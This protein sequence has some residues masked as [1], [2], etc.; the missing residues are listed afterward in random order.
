M[1]PGRLRTFSIDEAAAIRR[2][3]V[4]AR[5]PVSRLAKEYHV[6]QGTMTRLLTCQG[7]YSGDPDPVTI[8]GSMLTAEQVAEARRKFVD[9]NVASR[10]LAADYGVSHTRMNDVLAGRNAYAKYPNPVKVPAL[11]HKGHQKINDDD[12]PAIRARRAQGTSYAELGIEYNVAPATIMNVVMGKGR[13][14]LID[15]D[16]GLPVRTS[17]QSIPAT[18]NVVD[19]VAAMIRSGRSAREII[20][21]V[22][23]RTLG[24]S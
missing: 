13:F 9:D 3:Y 8:R 2:H 18:D 7:P 12:V 21:L 23:Q 22:R 14:A 6:A 1:S 17:A 24:P 15:G 5:I 19:A 16:S 10:Q 20:A 4:E 11:P